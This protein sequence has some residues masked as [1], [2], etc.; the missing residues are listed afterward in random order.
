MQDEAS[1]VTLTY[2]PYGVSKSLSE[3]NLSLF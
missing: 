1:K 3:S 2:G